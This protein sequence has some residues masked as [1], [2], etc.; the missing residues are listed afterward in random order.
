VLLGG[1]GDDSLDGGLGRD[2]LAG[3]DGDDVIV[4]LPSEID[5]AFSLS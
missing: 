5:E 3:N 4:G 2:T 1:L